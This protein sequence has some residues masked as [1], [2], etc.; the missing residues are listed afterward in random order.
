MD[1]FQKDMEGSIQFGLQVY[2]EVLR[3]KT[4]RVVNECDGPFS[5]IYNLNR[6]YNL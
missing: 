6:L 1:E 4:L 2:G 3:S 5:H